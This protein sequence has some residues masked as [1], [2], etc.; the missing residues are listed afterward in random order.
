M[1]DYLAVLRCVARFI[2]RR[3]VILCAFGVLLCPEATPGQRSK[4]SRDPVTPSVSDP[5]L[6]AV[7]R[8]A[9]NVA[10]AALQSNSLAQAERAARV[11]VTASPRSATTH[12]VLGVVLDRSGRS[13]E[14]FNEFNTAVKLDPQFISARNNLGRML[15]ERGRTAE[16]IAQF[17]SVLKADP[18][19]VQAHYNL[20]ALYADAGDF[21][22]AAEHFARARARAPEDPQ[23]ALAFS[24]VAYRANRSA[25]ADAAAELIE[26]VAASDPRVLFTLGTELAQNEQYE[27]TARIFARV[28]EKTPHTYEVL[29]NLGVALY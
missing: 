28:N 6:S 15:A 22:K 19:H 7:A 1:T 13:D 23:L 27:R 20:G 21:V 25:E 17:E 3:V 9:L 11:A 12:N 18:T 14:A 5:G 24:N 29:Y 16:A 10:V 2:A 4:G 8:E 26:R